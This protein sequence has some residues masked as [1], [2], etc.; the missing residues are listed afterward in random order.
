MIQ[1][2]ELKER[3]TAKSPDRKCVGLVVGSTDV[4]V[5]VV[6]WSPVAEKVFDSL[7]KAYDEAPDGQFPDVAC[8]NMCRR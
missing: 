8:K 3:P 5:Q 7:V 2:G 4:L 6:L 1:I